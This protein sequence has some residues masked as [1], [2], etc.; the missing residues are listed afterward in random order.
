MKFAIYCRCGGMP[1]EGRDLQPFNTKAEAVGELVHMRRAMADSPSIARTQWNEAEVHPYTGSVKG[2]MSV[3][4]AE[5]SL[6]PTPPA[7]QRLM[8][9]FNIPAEVDMMSEV[10]AAYKEVIMDALYAYRNGN[11]SADTAALVDDL[12]LES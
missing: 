9:G 1:N 8:V 3:E 5:R 2:E 10:A 12:L 6:N 11:L 7:T 4:E